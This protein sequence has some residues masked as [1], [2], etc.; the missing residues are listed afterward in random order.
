MVKSFDHFVD[1]TSIS[2][3]LNKVRLIPEAWLLVSL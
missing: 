1:R 2:E 3:V